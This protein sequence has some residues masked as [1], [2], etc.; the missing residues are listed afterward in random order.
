MNI[1]DLKIDKVL[2][3]RRKAIMG[4]P[5]YVVRMSLFNNMTVDER[6]FVSR[7]RYAIRMSLM[8]K[9]TVDCIRNKRDRIDC[10]K[11]NHW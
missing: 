11:R 9:V 6:N 7:L 1:K 3:E 5:G 4:R 10:G 8:N 2:E